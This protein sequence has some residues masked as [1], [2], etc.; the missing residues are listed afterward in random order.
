MPKHGV[1]KRSKQNVQTEPSKS[2]NGSSSSGSDY[3]P[4]VSVEDAKDNTPPDV[5]I[6]PA[7][8]APTVVVS[9]PPLIAPS[10]APLIADLEQKV[11]QVA[12][13]GL[14][15]L[16]TF[17]SLLAVR[18]G[19]HNVEQY[20]AHY[21]RPVVKGSTTLQQFIDRNTHLGIEFLR[22]TISKLADRTLLSRVGAAL[23]GEPGDGMQD[24]VQQQQSVM[25]QIFLDSMLKRAA[26]SQHA[27][28]DWAFTLMDDT[29]FHYILNATTLG[30]M[31]LSVSYIR[32]VEGCSTFT[33]KELVMSEG[34][35][36]IFAQ[37]CAYH[38]LIA[39]GGSAYAGRAQ[40]TDRGKVAGTNLMVSAGLKTRQLMYIQME[41]AKIWFENVYRSGKKLVHS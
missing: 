24:W 6:A 11:E 8:P 40:V 18:L 16:Y 7:P 5:F 28:S 22:E 17:V 34:V 21:Q 38:F 27:S 30:A 23:V 9:P 37:V 26:P 4:P 25:D 33:L 31:L 12:S 19:D 32:R 3:E 41:G 35:R 14:Q 2:T 10:T 1:K 13:S 20:Y 39:S 29:V 15:H 36:D